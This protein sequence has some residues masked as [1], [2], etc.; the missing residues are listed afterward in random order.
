MRAL[1]VLS[2]LACGVAFGSNLMA[3]QG[4]I[5]PKAGCRRNPGVV[6]RC[7]TVH[8]RLFVS[9]GTPSMRMWP[10][11]TQRILGVLPS[12]EELVPDVVKRHANFE[13][14]LYGDFEVCPFTR[15]K[16]GEMQFVCVESASNLVAEQFVDGKDAPIVFRIRK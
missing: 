14:R 16:A 13:T 10:V 15:E 9:N 12:E 11:G 8:G 7:R 6:D 4:Q 1:V 3:S 5:D 2:A